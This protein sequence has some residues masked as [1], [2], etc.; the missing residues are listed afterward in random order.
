MPDYRSTAGGLAE[1]LL[2]APMNSDLI[3]LGDLSRNTT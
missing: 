1:G 3:G 2:A